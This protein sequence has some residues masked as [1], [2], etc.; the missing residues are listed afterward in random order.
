MIPALAV[1]SSHP[2]SLAGAPLAALAYY[3]WV[4]TVGGFLLWYAGSARTSAAR[5]ALATA[6]M[7]VSALLLAA[8]LLDEPVRLWQWL[9]LA[10]VLGAMLLSLPRAST[11]STTTSPS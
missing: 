11:R 6:C 1:R 2:S 10:C 3:A 7:P 9:G 5:A 4:P 8:L